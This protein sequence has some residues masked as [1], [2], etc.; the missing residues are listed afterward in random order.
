MSQGRKIAT[1]DLAGFPMMTTNEILDCLLALGITVQQE[2]VT[3]PS[4]QSAQMIYAAL[5]DAL[6]GAP[7]ELL[8]QPK[9]ALMG[10]ME[11][12]ELYGDALHFTMFLHHCRELSVLCGITNFSISD[13]TRPE[14]ARLRTIL[15]GIMNFAK[16]RDERE[17]FHQALKQKVQKQADNAKNAADTPLTEEART[18]NEGIRNELLELR[19]Q[20][21]KLS[22]E[23]EELKTEKKSISNQARSKMEDITNLTSQAAQARSRL[24]QSPERIKRHIADMSSSTAAEKAALAGYQ[25]KA[26]ELGNRI[27]VIAGLEMDLKG[28]ID[29]EK[30][31]DEQ[32]GK[33]EEAKRAM[34]ALEERMSAKT[35]EFKG[36]EARL[37]QLERQL[38]NAGEKLLRQQEMV[39]DMRERAKS[40]MASLKADY[41]V[42]AKE[43]GLWQKEREQIL[44]EQR[45]VEAEMATFVAKH[46]GEI[47]ELLQEYWTMRKQAEDY[48]NTMTVK[49]GLQ[50]KV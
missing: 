9:A 7:M 25:R 37:E 18:R 49:L 21:V 10:M 38:H 28:L 44:A 33:V 20:Q 1:Q 39:K 11:Y 47:N 46:E 23:V 50:I 42:R 29:L 48:M 6:M 15:S 19:S 26:R 41:V 45:E 16:F 27:D 22:H 17:A 5:L 3:K 31:I 36:H 35:I 40:K 32:R 13:L 24:V 34:Q 8:E 2:D 14:G 12:K 30:G 4:A 43:R